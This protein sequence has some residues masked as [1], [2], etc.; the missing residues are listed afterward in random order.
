MLSVRG[1]MAVSGRCRLCDF[2]LRLLSCRDVKS[3]LTKSRGK[4]E[5]RLAISAGGKYMESI[6]PVEH[7]TWATLKDSWSTGNEEAVEILCVLLLLGG[8]TYA[9]IGRREESVRLRNILLL[10]I[11]AA[12]VALDENIVHAVRS[13]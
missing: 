8:V 4:M 2:S 9:A 6:F 7:D 10:C 3:K 11:L 13:K 1:R 5:V 12:A